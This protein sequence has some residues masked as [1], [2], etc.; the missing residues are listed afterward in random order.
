[1]VGNARESPANASPTQPQLLRLLLL[2]HSSSDC[3]A[4]DVVVATGRV[5]GSLHCLAADLQLLEVDSV[6][7]PLT[8]VDGW[9]WGHLIVCLVTGSTNVPI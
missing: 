6:V 7:M 1:M 9:L 2:L 4:I 8:D 3:R 5:Q